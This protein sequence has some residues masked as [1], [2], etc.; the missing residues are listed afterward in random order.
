M[1]SEMT[2]D[3]R[4]FYPTDWEAMCSQGKVDDH[5]SEHLGTSDRG[6]LMLRRML[7]REIK[8]IQ[9]GGDPTGVSFEASR[10]R[11]K[12]TAGNYFRDAT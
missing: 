12:T 5:I 10:A 11:V 9:D 7:K 3:E 4:Q 8:S 1:W 6:V 2:E